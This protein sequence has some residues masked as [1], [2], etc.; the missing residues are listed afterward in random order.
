VSLHGTLETFALPDVMALLAAT[1]KTGELRVVG[2]RIDGRVYLDGGR[3]VSTDVGRSDSF[4]DAVF[5]LLRL[6]SGKFSFDADAPA[7][8]SGEP[9]DVEPL[10]LEAGARLAEWRDIEAVVPSMDHGVGL[11]GD[12]GDPHVTLAAEQW[13][14]VVA[15]A[16]ARCVHEVAERLGLGEYGACKSLKGL[17][18]SGVVVVSDPPA[19]KAEPKPVAKAEA[20]AAKAE[21]VKAEPKPE[22]KAKPDEAEAVEAAE[23][24]S[25]ARSEPK[26]ESKADEP[27]AVVDGKAKPVIEPQR[28][29]DTTVGGVEIP[30]LTTKDQT[31]PIPPGAEPTGSAK[32]KKGAKGEDEAAEPATSVTEPATGVTEPATGATDEGK[33]AAVSASEAK[34]LVSQLAALSSDKPAA[35]SGADRLEEST[36][37]AAAGS[38]PAASA[39]AGEGGDAEEPLNRGLL[40]K[41][42]SSVRQ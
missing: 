12:L 16:G 13:R 28:K 38:E 3:V 41:F 39:A 6:T 23:P 22:A 9:V 14:M 18:E 19:A 21:P 27:P 37:D 15:V 24:K 30:A 36:A 34:Q 42:L 29:P 2:G 8:A 11:V 10:L 31:S 1:K 35:K 33:A 17:V 4:V 25:E 7:G 20:P 26:S 32:A 5:E 40:L